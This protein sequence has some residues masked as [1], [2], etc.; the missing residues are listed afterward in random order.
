[1]SIVDGQIITHT[2]LNAA[3]TDGYRDSLETEAQRIPG[4]TLMQWTFVNVLS[5]TDSELRTVTFNA[6]DD[7]EIIDVGCFS[8]DSNSAGTITAAL[9]GVFVSGSSISLTGTHSAV[10]H[11]LTRYNAT[12]GRPFEIML[13]GANYTWAVSTDQSSG[14]TRIIPWVLVRSHLRRTG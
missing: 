6:P 11:Q 3:F 2:D 5:G 7:L 10:S 4:A 13:K 12:S 8:Y 1:M 14:T 9:S